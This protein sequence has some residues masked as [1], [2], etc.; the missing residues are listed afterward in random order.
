MFTIDSKLEIDHFVILEKDRKIF[1][2]ARRNGQ[3]YL[4][5]IDEGSGRV[6]TH[7]R[8]IDSWDELIDSDRKGILA[9]ITAAENRRI[10]I[11]RIRSSVRVQGCDDRDLSVV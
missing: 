10:P 9:R 8:R 11:Y 6:Y 5:L 1:V 2:A 3:L 4:F 7:N